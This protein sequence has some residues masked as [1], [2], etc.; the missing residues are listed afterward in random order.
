MS[1]T[2]SYH[3]DLLIAKETMNQLK[4]SYPL[5]FEKLEHIVQLT[6]ALHFKYQYMG[7]LIM[8]EEPGTACPNFVSDSVL[9]LYSSEIEK[10]KN[11]SHI[12]I[13][14]QTLNKLNKVGYDNISL[15]VLG[16]EPESIVGIG[17]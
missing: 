2:V 8:D 5:T 10:L 12:H 3:N 17:A 4:N 16:I 6:R 7:C 15:L 9:N 11:D 1:I 13:I 14:K